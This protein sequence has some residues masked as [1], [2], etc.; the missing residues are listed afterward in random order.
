[1]GAKMARMSKKLA[2]F[3]AEVAAF[4]VMLGIIARWLWPRVKVL[5]EARQRQ[6]AEQLAAA[7]ETRHGA[8]R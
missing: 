8:D 4:L 6:V 5:A 7:A 3:L 1:M 2:D